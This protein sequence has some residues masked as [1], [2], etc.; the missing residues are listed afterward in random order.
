MAGNGW[1]VQPQKLIHSKNLAVQW[2]DF[3][4]RAD[5]VTYTRGKHFFNHMSRLPREGTLPST[6][7][8]VTIEMSIGLL[9]IHLIFTF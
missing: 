3:L 8:N 2:V 1:G 5:S 4:L 7:S 6:F 9:K